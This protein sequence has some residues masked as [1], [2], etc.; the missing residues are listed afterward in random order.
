M[1]V[2][3]YFINNTCYDI[4][5]QTSKMQL[6]FTNNLSLSDGC[7]TDQQNYTLIGYKHNLTTSNDRC[8]LQIS[9]YTL[10]NVMCDNNNMRNETSS[11]TYPNGQISI[12]D[13][14]YFNDNMMSY[15]KK[16]IVDCLYDKG[17]FDPWSNKSIQIALIVVVVFLF[18]L[19]VLDVVIK[20]MHKNDIN[21]I[22]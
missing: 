16:D 12:R 22:V 4:M 5:D 2:Y 15:F 10:T 11:P 7:I 21:S 1:Y 20:I 9:N 17:C 18:L 6:Y 13:T 14:E 8:Y 19:A 3:T